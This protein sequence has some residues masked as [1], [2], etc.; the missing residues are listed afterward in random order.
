MA[1]TVTIAEGE[2]LIC[3]LVPLTSKTQELAGPFS[4][5]EAGSDY[6]VQAGVIEGACYDEAERLAELGV[7]F[8][9][10]H[11]SQE[12]DADRA[13]DS[14]GATVEAA[15]WLLDAFRDPAASAS[16]DMKA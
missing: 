8:F 1:I 10:A 9:I 6:L 11:V 12:L 4:D 2:L 7:P 3:I 13:Q 5:K 16:A 14:S 15:S